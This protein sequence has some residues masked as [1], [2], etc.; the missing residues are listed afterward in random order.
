MKKVG[1]IGWRGM[2]GSVLVQRMQAND[3]FQHF[4]RTFF[5]TSQKGQAAPEIG[6]GPGVLGDAFN[7]DLLKPM[8]II[9]SCQGSE[10]TQSIYPRLREQGWNGFWIDAASS[11]RLKDESVIVLD[12]INH[13]Q[14]TKRIDSGCRTLVGGN[15]TVSIML[16][17][18]AGLLKP[19]LIE[20]ISAMSYQAISGAGAKAIEELFSQTCL[21]PPDLGK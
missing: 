5:S 8:D 11:L 19:Q 9:I 14:I 7:M 21:F 6:H 10:Y 3:D 1:I 18:L 20:W 17:G 16:L 13:E 4:E 15:C 12:P 2:V